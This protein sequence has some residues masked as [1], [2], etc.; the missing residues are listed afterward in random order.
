[1]ALLDLAPSIQEVIL[2]MPRVSKGRDPLTER[3]L[4]TIVAETDW[5]RQITL[6]NAIYRPAA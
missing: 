5:D 6:W 1:M 2:F 3:S 4:R